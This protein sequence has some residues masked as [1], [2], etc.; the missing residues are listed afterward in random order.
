MSNFGALATFS[1]AWRP[2]RA[3]VAKERLQILDR[4]A[5]DARDEA[6][7]HDGMEA[8]EGAAAE[9]PIELDFPSREAP[10]EAFQCRGLV[11]REMID[12]RAGITL[13]RRDGSEPEAWLADRLRWLA[14]E[15]DRYVPPLEVEMGVHD[16]G[17]LEPLG[18]VTG[19]HVR[20]HAARPDKAALRRG[21]RAA[22]ENR[23]KRR[24]V[25]LFASTLR[26][27]TCSF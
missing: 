5:L 23:E 17:P 25:L 12:V 11:G 20:R 2:M 24:Q 19:E 6:P 14:G 4:V 10:H 9:Q 3:L 16:H 26:G 21:R 13:A 15:Q 8:D 1:G 18:R 22:L 27:S 7:P